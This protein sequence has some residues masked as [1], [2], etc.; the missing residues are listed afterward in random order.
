MPQNTSRRFCL[1]LGANQHAS[2]YKK[3]IFLWEDVRVVDEAARDFYLSHPD[4]KAL[5]QTFN[6]RLWMMCSCSI[7]KQ[8]DEKVAVFRLQF[9]YILV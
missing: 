9:C 6:V 2:R 3:D 8:I 5:S 4:H 1:R 7:M